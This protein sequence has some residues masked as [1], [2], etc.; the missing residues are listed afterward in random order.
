MSHQRR[1]LPDLWF[2]IT[3]RAAT[4]ETKSTADDLEAVRAWLG[5][6]KMNLFSYSYGTR[7]VLTFMRH[8]PGSVR[9]AILWGVVPPDY[10]RSLYYARDSQTAME[11]LLADCLADEPCRRAFPNVEDG[12]SASHAEAPRNRS[13]TANFHYAC[14]IRTGIVG[15]AVASGPG[16]QAADRNSS[17]R[18][19]RLRT[20]PE[21]G[22]SDCAAASS[23][24]QRGAPLHRLP[25]GGAAHSTLGD[26]GA[27]SRCIH[28][29]RTYL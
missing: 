24:L 15:S 18:A 20:V 13:A 16:A 19:R 4:H 26:R 11:R 3:R 12:A 7:A 22:C 2:L 21:D 28:A 29:A 10:R 25:R 17:C 23:L 27:A 5:Y 1:A 6:S 14:G 9:S 8:Y